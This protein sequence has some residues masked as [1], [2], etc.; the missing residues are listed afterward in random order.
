MDFKDEL[1]DKRD[2]KEFR[3][4]SFS[5]YKKTNVKNELLSSL[6][7]S[8]IESA[9]Y[10]T[11][12]LV[13]AGHYL[14][15]WEVLLNYYY[16]FIHNGNPKL[17]IYL[18]YRYNQFITIW[19]CGYLD[20]ELRMRNNDKIRK[21]FCELACFLSLAKKKHSLKAIKIDKNDFLITQMGDKLKAPSV[22]YAEPLFKE[23]DPQALFVAINELVYHLTIKN[24]VQVCFWMEWI[25]RYDDMCKK[26]KEVC[27]CERRSQ[28]PVD[29]KFQRDLIFMI[30]DVFLYFTDEKKTDIVDPL[31]KKAI[32]STLSLYCIKYTSNSFKKLRFYLYFVASLLTELNPLEQEMIPEEEKIRVSK[33]TGNVNVLYRQIKKNEVSPKT[34]YLFKNMKQNNL[35]KTIE[36]LEL[37]NKLE[38]DGYYPMENSDSSDSDSDSN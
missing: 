38:M 8:K 15:I 37:L 33:I 32:D 35:E 28:M 31:V 24:C 27:L 18:E 3:M 17:S 26:K 5:G 2:I 29:A 6:Y 16:Q 19:K 1:N 25:M 30:W 21:L 22:K 23:S 36:K 7:G 11:A 14:D 10:W 13:S 9:C 4:I 12:E 34:E 20:M